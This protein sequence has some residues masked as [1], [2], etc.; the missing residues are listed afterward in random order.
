MAKQL[1]KGNEAIAYAAILGGADVFFGYP[2]TP[3]NEIP[4]YLSIEMF[5]HHKL[6]VQGESEV[7]S[8]NMVYGAAGAGARA[9][10]SSSSPGIA[11]MQEGI[12][13]LC[14]AE[15]PCVI[16]SVMR[17]GPGLGG[18]QPS[19]SDYNQATR[20][21]GN[22]DYHCLVYAP[23]NIQE[24]INIT[25]ES[26]EI[27]DC[28]RNPVIVLI[29]GLIGQM[30][31]AVDFDHV[32]KKRTLVDKKDYCTLGTKYHDHKNIV[33][34]LYLDP[35]DLEKHNIKLNEKYK[36]IQQEEVLVET[37][38]KIEQ[39][40]F[41]V[42]AYGT[43]ARIAKTAI[44]ELNQQGYKIGMIRPI[45]LWPFPYKTF[46]NLHQCKGI[47]VT[48]MSMGQML[49]DVL[50]ATRNHSVSVEFFG[51]TGGVIPEP[52]EVQ[53]AIKQL[54]SSKGGS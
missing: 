5:K 47:L 10:T 28:Y 14:G 21:G 26:F 45:T 29:D 40:E 41:I 52:D 51:R 7:A 24:A 37:T 9:M 1:L 50:I 39:A 42:V 18:I 19:Q 20:G 46:Q 3:Q 27:A 35:Y 31:E 8:I 32:N 34:S 2:I 43:M 16:I 23:A 13:Y 11:L 53:K 49:Q 36:K 54:I 17:G 15:L 12:S 22:G 38:D 25:K 30:M 6:F 4:E 44:N 48:E 33:N